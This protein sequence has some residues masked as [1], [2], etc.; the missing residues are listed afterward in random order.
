MK[1]YKYKKKKIKNI[2]D[3]LILYVKDLLIYEEIL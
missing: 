1:F 2:G 3:P